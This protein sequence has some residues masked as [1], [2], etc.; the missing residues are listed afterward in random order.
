MYVSDRNNSS[1]INEQLHNLMI[2]F[3]IVVVE[4]PENGGVRN[5]SVWTSFVTSIQRCKLD[6]IPDE[7]D[8]RAV[9]D[10]VLIAL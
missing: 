10:E 1:T 7:Y 4:I 8:G 5:G 6:W 3:W 2:A 9:Q